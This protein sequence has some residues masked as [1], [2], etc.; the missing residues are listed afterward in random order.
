MIFS[1]LS[2]SV[3]VWGGSCFEIG[4]HYVALHGLELAIYIKLALNSQRYTCLCLESK[5]CATVPGS[6]H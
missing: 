1:S 4:S 2:L 6:T 3:C 5:E